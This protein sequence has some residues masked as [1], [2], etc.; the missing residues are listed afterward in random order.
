MT[1]NYKIIDISTWPRWTHCRVFREAVQPQYCITVE[2]D[3]TNFREK[4]RQNGWSFTLAFIYAVACCANEI[5]EFRYRFLGDDIV[6]YDSIDTS[7]S[8]ISEGDDL[9]KFINA[10]LK[11]T[12]EDYIDNTTE[13]IAAQ[14]EYF[15]GPPKPDTYIFSA[16][17][18]LN[19]THVSH[20]ETGQKDKANP[21]FDWGK[22]HERDNRIVMPFSVQVHHSFVDGIHV[23]RLVDRLQR[24]LDEL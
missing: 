6:L 4:V 21:M 14:K 2:V 5:E 19:Y 8:Y 16:L 22:Y 15:T 13:I 18:W 20:T 24:Y 9:F 1:D 3:V 23:A 11:P 10:P 7:F 17:P 12:I